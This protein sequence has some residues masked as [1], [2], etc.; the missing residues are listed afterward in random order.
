MKKSRLWHKR[1]RKK[2][3]FIFNQGDIN[4]V[5][6]HQDLLVVVK[7]FVSLRKRIKNHVG[8]CPFCK[9]L[10]TNDA[11]FIVNE[12]KRRYKCF[13]CGRSGATAASFLMQYFDAPFDKV[14]MFLNN[15]YGPNINLAYD[16]T[17]VLK[18]HSGTDDG[19]PF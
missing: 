19:L 5:M 9:P 7:D 10:T 11:H 16:R 1:K 2:S 14:L 18:N 12:K 13:E 3:Y 8:R 17:R 15:K 6:F 4:K